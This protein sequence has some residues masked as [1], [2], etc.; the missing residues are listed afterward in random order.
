MVDVVGVV[1]SYI[2][3]LLEDAG[4]GMKVHRI[5]PDLVLCFSAVIS[6]FQCSHLNSS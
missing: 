6:L 1:Q 4:P 2:L 3:R 5:R